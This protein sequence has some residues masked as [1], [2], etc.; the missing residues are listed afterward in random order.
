V[1]IR[2]DASPSADST[3][4]AMIERAKGELARQPDMEASQITVL[5]AEAVEWPDASLGCPQPDMMYAQVITPG[6]RIVL[7]AGGKAYEYHTDQRQAV[8][9]CS[10]ESQDSATVQRTLPIFVQVVQVL[11]P[12]G[13]SLGAQGTDPAPN[14]VFA[15]NPADRTLFLR[16]SIDVHPETQVLIGQTTSI[17]EP[18]QT[19]TRGELFQ[20]PANEASPLEI[21]AIDAETGGLTLAYAGQVFELLPGQSRSLK[22][23]AGQATEVTSVTHMGRPASIEPFPYSPDAR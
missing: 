23:A 13:S 17:G 4:Q 22:Q 5:E 20:V 1:T 15:Y 8:V 2:P 10:Q 6:Y 9:L 3:L 16:P 19:P 18:G 14:S 12:P 7:E 11:L 21:I